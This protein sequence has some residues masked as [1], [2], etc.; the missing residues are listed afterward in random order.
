MNGPECSAERKKD[1]EAEVGK[2]RTLWV[3]V[4][5]DHAEYGRW[6][7]LEIRDPWDAQYEIRTPLN[8]RGLGYVARS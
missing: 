2:A 1:K 4:V 7:Y 5:N 3:P 8:R 6:A